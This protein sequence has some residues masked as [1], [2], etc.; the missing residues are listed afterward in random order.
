MVVVVEIKLDLISPIYIYI[1]FGSFELV[2][3][4]KI[5]RVE[6]NYKQ[7]N[8]KDKTIMLNIIFFR[9]RW[10]NVLSMWMN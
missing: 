2:K 6:K 5:K 4:R 7:F 10:H 3:E 1:A 9:N 8:K